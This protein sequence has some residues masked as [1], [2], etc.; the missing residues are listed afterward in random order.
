MFIMEENKSFNPLNICFFS[1]NTVMKQT[2]NVSCLI[3]KAGF[4]YGSLLHILKFHFCT[5]IMCYV[6][7]LNKNQLIM[8]P[9]SHFTNRAF[10]VSNC[11]YA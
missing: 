10:R 6:F 4:I 2:H 1:A 8:P 11:S 9:K 5:L 7:D 3:N